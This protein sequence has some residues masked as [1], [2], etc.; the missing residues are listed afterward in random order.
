MFEQM[1]VDCAREGSLRKLN[2]ALVAK[3]L[4]QSLLEAFGKYDAAMVRLICAVAL[5]IPSFM[6]EANE[7]NKSE[8]LRRDDCR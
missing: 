8:G 2:N 6:R 4:F 3:D 5:G 1:M 7:V